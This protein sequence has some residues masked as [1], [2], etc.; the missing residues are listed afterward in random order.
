MYRSILVWSKDGAIRHPREMN[1][2][3]FSKPPPRTI[4]R[5]V[6]ATTEIHLL[7][8]SWIAVGMHRA[9]DEN[10]TVAGSV[11]SAEEDGD[12]VE[13]VEADF[14]LFGFDGLFVV[15]AAAAAAAADGALDWDD[16]LLD[17]EDAATDDQLIGAGGAAALTFAGAA[18]FFSAFFSSFCCGAGGYNL[19]WNESAVNSN[20]R[21][22]CFTNF[23]SIPAAGDATVGWVLKE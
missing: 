1:R 5:S 8:N 15:V 13:V 14:A 21:A 11:G 7:F 18:A 16:S 17:T 6:S 23:K 4:W 22:I 10:S 9:E 19:I 20:G 12:E 2:A 3:Y